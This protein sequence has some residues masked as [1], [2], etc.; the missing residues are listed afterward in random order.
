LTSLPTPGAE[1]A[2]SRG[3]VE[4]VLRIVDSFNARDIGEALRDVADGFELDCSN[5]IGPLKGVCRGRDAAGEA[6]R[7]LLN[8]WMTVYWDPVEV[9]DIDDSRVV[10]VNRSQMRRRGIYADE[11]EAQLWTVRG[12]KAERLKLYQSRS[13]TLEAAGLRE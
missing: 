2:T 4:I 10:V 6:W 9:I 1:R 5:S 3:K 11:I 8:A 7:S 13:E 12:G